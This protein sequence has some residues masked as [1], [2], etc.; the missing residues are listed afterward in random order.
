MEFLWAIT[1]LPAVGSFL[2]RHSLI[3]CGLFWRDEGD[4]FHLL[5]PPELNSGSGC[6]VVANCLHTALNERCSPYSKMIQLGSHPP[7]Q[8]ATHS[9]IYLPIHPPAFLFQVVGQLVPISSGPL[10]HWIKYRY[11]SKHWN[12]VKKFY[13]LSVISE[14]EKRILYRFNT[15]WV[16]YIKPLL[17]V[18]LII[19]AY[20]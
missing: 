18:I 3:K 10:S 12:I 6:P 17:H 2:N 1:I 4:L 8:P 9:L 14:S 13:F 11:F 5:L 20:K 7:T 16:K 19:M 15:H